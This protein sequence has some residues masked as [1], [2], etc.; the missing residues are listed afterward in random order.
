MNLLFNIYDDR[1][2]FLIILKVYTEIFV[3]VLALK[4]NSR[5]SFQI[6]HFE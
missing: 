5:Q 4:I 2:F 6:F 3:L 1:S